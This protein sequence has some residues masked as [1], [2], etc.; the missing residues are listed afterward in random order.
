MVT[1]AAA[2]RPRATRPARPAS[3]RAAITRTTTIAIT[4][5]PIETTSRTASTLPDSADL[6]DSAPRSD[7]SLTRRPGTVSTLVT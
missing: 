3:R 6:V 5:E 1:L 4:S 7:A 2:S